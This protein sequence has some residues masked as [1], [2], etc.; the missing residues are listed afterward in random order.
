[1][2]EKIFNSVGVMVVDDEEFARKHVT[3]ILNRIGAGE[4][5][6]A[7]NG[8]EALERMG[9]PERD[10]DPIICD[11]EM[12]EMDGYELVRRIRY[13]EVPKFKD[14]PIVVL[15]GKD[16]D[17]NVQPARVLRI[18]GFLVKPPDIKVFER[19]IRR[20]L[21]E[22]ICQALGIDGEKD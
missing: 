16:T 17:K 15:T 20:I 9:E 8:V 3:R 21:S 18:D 12:P 22:R 11:V 13:G 4:V 7:G 19:K 1:M 5:V 6:T 10:I 2:V 14:V